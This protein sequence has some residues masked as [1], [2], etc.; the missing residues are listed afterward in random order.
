MGSL[1]IRGLWSSTP[2]PRL[3][4]WYRRGVEFLTFRYLSRFRCVGTA[5]QDHC[6]QAWNVTVDKTHHDKLRERMSSPDERAEFDAGIRR[7]EEKSKPGQYAFT[8]LRDDGT[9]SFLSADRLCTIHG[10]YG[11]EYL[12]DACAMY[13]RILGWM[14]TRA[15]L[16]AA[17]SCPEVARMVLF[18]E[19]ALDLVPADPALVVRRTLSRQVGIK[20]KD[21]YDANFLSVR[22]LVDWLLRHPRYPLATRL[23]FVTYFAEESR[24]YLH[25]GAKPFDAAA[26][27]K[28]G[29]SFE[30]PETLAVLHRAYRRAAGDPVFAF[31]VVREMLGLPGKLMPRLLRSLVDE[32][33]TAFAE[34]GAPLTGD[35]EPIAEAYKTLPPLAP[36]LTARLDYIIDRYV[37]HDLVRTWFINEASFIGYYH[38][39]LSRVATLRFLIGGLARLRGSVDLAAFDALAIQGV[40]LLSRAIDHNAPLMKE[41]L[42]AHERHGMR[43]EYAVSMIRM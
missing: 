34:R 9:C 13:P 4:P 23:F 10:R 28:L 19:G 38:S 37:I 3:R 25:R 2:R 16:V 35:A 14:N 43:L 1:R 39:L 8:V 27:Q 18:E 6:C 7:G 30:D 26:L 36:E 29:D 17:A 24:A 20:H 40:Y 21:P 12:S 5:C 15:E 41:I 22:G 11:E 33:N 32:L 31:A 42:R